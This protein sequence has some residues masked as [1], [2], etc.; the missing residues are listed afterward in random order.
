[1]P[2]CGKKNKYVKIFWGGQRDSR[3]DKVLNLHAANEGL[4]SR[5]LSGSS[6]LPEVISE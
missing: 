4:M 3:A 6:N 2:L 5:T 1:M